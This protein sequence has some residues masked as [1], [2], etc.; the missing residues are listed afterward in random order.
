MSSQLFLFRPLAVSP[1]ALTEKN[2]SR[3]TVVVDSTIDQASSPLAVRALATDNTLFFPAKDLL[4][5]LKGLETKDATLQF[6]DFEALKVEAPALPAAQPAAKKEK[7]D[8]KIE[9]AVQ[10]AIG[11]KKEVDFA[12]WY[13]N[14]SAQSF[15]PPS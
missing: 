5:Y 13:T 14:V 11:L 12:G 15:L 7:A 1:L 9:G 2:F 4:A 3:V 6:I 8:A 10:I